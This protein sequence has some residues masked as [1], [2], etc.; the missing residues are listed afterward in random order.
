MSTDQPNL[1][2]PPTPRSVVA[3]RPPREWPRPAEIPIEQATKIRPRITAL[4]TSLNEEKNIEA[5]I[6]SVLWCD[7][8]LLVDS[9]SSDA[10]VAIASRF[11]RVRI[12]KRTYLGCASQ[13]NWAID[14]AAND[15]I[16]IL[17][18]DE[19]V[20][21]ELRSEIELLLSKTPDTNKAFSVPRKT[22]FLG[23][24]MRYSGWQ[25]DRVIRFFHRLSARYPNRRVHADMITR[26]PAH[27]LNNPLIHFMVDDLSEY[28]D[29][30]Q[31]Y[32]KL[33]ASQLWKDGRKAGLYEV[34]CHPLWRFLRTYF[35]QFGC[36]EGLSGLVLCAIHSWAVFL[37]WSILWGW[38]RNLKQGHQPILPAF[39]DNP[40]TWAWPTEAPVS[41]PDQERLHASKH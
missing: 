34:I 22:Y 30:L 25:N 27:I 26:Q 37:K 28:T 19:R 18:A 2:T 23:R 39:D 32:A 35:L 36:I 3:S 1:P 38:H 13:K 29:R 33:G 16:L 24:R 12:L 15:W 10:T 9:H 41:S 11:P 40:E 17:D 4:I 31:C 8:I 7:E 21:P 5:C 20:T 6:R 14:R